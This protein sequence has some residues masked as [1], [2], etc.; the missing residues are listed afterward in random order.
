[1]KIF[2]KAKLNAKEER[3]ERI[4]ENNFIVAV[5]EPPVDGKANQAILKAL[6]EY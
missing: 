2:V 5:K 6:A 1:M 3:V 4:D